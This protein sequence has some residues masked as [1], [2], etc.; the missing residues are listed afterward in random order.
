MYD[1]IYDSMVDSGVAIRK[2]I[3][4]YKDID[5]RDV[6]ELS[7][8]RVGELCDLE[9]IH[10][11]HLLFA[12]ETGVNTNQRN[13]GHEGNTRFV[14]EQGSKPRNRSLEYDSLGD[15]YVNDA[16]SCS[17]RAHA[18]ISELPKLLPHAAGYLLREEA[19]Q[20]SNHF[21]DADKPL[22]AVVGGAKISTKLALLENLIQR[23][24][25]RAFRFDVHRDAAR[26]PIAQH[27]VEP[28]RPQRGVTRIR[29][30]VQQRDD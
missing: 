8:D 25:V 4:S 18:S 14:V 13:D 28:L 16:F 20:L 17:H 12:D 24:D 26:A 2:S 11:D 7:P 30:A 6:D 9:I 21:D 22:A 15:A 5:G 23:V 29:Q 27:G 10:L 1:N 19:T 3:P